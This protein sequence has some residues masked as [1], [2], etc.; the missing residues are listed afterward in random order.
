MRQGRRPIPPGTPPRSAVAGWAVGILLVAAV[1]FALY[2]WGAG[3]A[4]LAPAT[5]P[6]TTTARTQTKARSTPSA[7]STVPSTRT[8]REPMPTDEPSGWRRVFA[9]DFNGSSL[10]QTRWRVY[11]GSP[12]GDPAGWFDP[13]HVTVSDGRLMI[14]AYRDRARPGRLGHRRRFEQSRTRSRSTASTWCGFGS[15]P[16][17]G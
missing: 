4:H 10:D 14:G 6:T 13:S 17:S 9:D 12:L 3:P 7:S 16:G 11:N 5:A 1:A 8:E 2:D 15:T